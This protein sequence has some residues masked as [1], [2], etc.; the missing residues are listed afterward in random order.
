MVK[1]QARRAWSACRVRKRRPV[2]YVVP[3]EQC[4]E[5]LRDKEPI[6]AVVREWCGESSTGRGTN[7]VP[8]DIK[9][10]MRRN[11]AGGSD[12]MRLH[13]RAFDVESGLIEMKALREDG[14][15][16]GASASCE[17]DRSTAVI[18]SHRRGVE[19]HREVPALSLE[20][21][22]TSRR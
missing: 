2:E 3:P 20:D 19:V 21:M 9:A 1:F 11:E 15:C 16:T 4:A 7:F 5:Y 14:S 18:A 6:Y 12:L 22:S 17:A 13:F 8:P 10:H